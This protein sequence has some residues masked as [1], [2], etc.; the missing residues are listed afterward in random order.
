MIIRKYIKIFEEY[1]YNQMSNLQQ[2]AINWLTDYIDWVKLPFDYALSSDFV[3]KY[4]NKFQWY[5]LSTIKY[6]SDPKSTEKFFK[7]YHAYID[8]SAISQYHKLTENFIRD[9]YYALN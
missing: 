4:S 1:S 6:S 8:W 3:K 7:Y 9:Y 2:I 5:I